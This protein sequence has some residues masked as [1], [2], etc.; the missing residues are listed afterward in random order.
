MVF[1]EKN[2]VCGYYIGQKH[3]F[4]L[5]SGFPFLSLFEAGQRQ[6]LYRHL[7]LVI[8]YELMHF[9]MLISFFKNY[10]QN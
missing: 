2:K 3:V 5:F 8:T 10:N 1:D 7:Q 9:I 6:R 4:V